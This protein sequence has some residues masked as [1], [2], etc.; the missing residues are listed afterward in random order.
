M[1]S[2]ALSPV[3]TLAKHNETAFLRRSK[4][5]LPVTSMKV[6]L[7]GLSLGTIVRGHVKV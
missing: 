3:R 6:R 1:L 5:S 4:T 7:A 2:K